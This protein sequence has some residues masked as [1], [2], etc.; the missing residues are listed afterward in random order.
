MKVVILFAFSIASAGA[1]AADRYIDPA[2][3][4]IDEKRAALFVQARK[5]CAS[6]KIVGERRVCERASTEEANAKYPAR[7]TVHYSKKMYSNLTKEQAVSKLL[8]L[9]S[10]DDKASGGSKAYPGEITK[11]QVEAEASWIQSNILGRSDQAG[12][13]PFYV[14]CEEQPGGVYEHLCE[15]GS[16]KVVT[17]PVPGGR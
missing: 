3:K 17:K 5:K 10:I 6:I 2:Q 13:T 4:I 16:S 8:E 14:P 7:G 12:P 9:K 15:V 11:N 1:F